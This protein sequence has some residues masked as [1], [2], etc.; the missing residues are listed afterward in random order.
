[1]RAAPNRRGHLF[2]HN[3]SLVLDLIDLILCK[4]SRQRLGMS[5]LLVSSSFDSCSNGRVNLAIISVGREAGRIDRLAIS[6]SGTAIIY[7][8]FLAR[9]AGGRGKRE[10]SEDSRQRQ[11]SRAENFVPAHS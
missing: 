5:S 6:G 11:R 1:M 9:R 8:S 2:R 10:L 4:V 7:K 3:N